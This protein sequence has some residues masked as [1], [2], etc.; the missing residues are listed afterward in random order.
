MTVTD[1]GKRRIYRLQEGLWEAVKAAETVDTSDIDSVRFQKLMIEG[2]ERFDLTEDVTIEWY[3]HGDHVKTAAVDLDQWGPSLG[4]NNPEGSRFSPLEPPKVE[5]A[6]YFYKKKLSEWNQKDWIESDFTTFLRKYYRTHE[7]VPYRRLYLATLDVHD[8][9][10][11]MAGGFNLSAGSNN[12][13]I[14][15]FEAGC[16]DLKIALMLNWEFTNHPAYINFIEKIGTLLANQLRENDVSGAG[17]IISQFDEFYYETVWDAIATTISYYNT[18]GFDHKDERN[19]RKE[20]LESA[21]DD[22]STRY[23]G[24]VEWVTDEADLPIDLPPFPELGSL[25]I[26]HPPR[27][28][29]AGS[30]FD[31]LFDPEYH[32]TVLKRHEPREAHGYEDLYKKEVQRLATEIVNK[33]YDPQ[34]QAYLPLETLELLWAVSRLPSDQQPISES[35]VLAS[36]ATFASD[37]DFHTTGTREGAKQS[38]DAEELALRLNSLID[39]FPTRLKRPQ[40]DFSEAELERASEYLKSFLSEWGPEPSAVAES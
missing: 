17:R 18:T 39:E 9:L 40:E 35:K 2:I 29:D 34:H 33:R 4:E 14:N 28:R 7:S 3:R 5:E 6:R 21:A 38:Y 27:N 37:Y 25:E 19:S 1:R 32:I 23:Q 30:E 12:Q 15:Q 24:F 10:I 31:G 16:R 8:A 20:E 11:D 13:A 22:I 36:L 26:E